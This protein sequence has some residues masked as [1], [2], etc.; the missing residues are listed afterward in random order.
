MRTFI[1]K[2]L[3]GY[4]MH[5][6]ETPTEAWAEANT[7]I[8]PLESYFASDKSELAE[9]LTYLGFKTIKTLTEYPTLFE[10]KLEE[11]RQGESEDDA[12][13]VADSPLTGW[14]YGL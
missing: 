2:T 14:L 6:A 8:V 4:T 13:P 7:E 1:Y 12:R 10:V 5:E 9:N 11:I 3:I